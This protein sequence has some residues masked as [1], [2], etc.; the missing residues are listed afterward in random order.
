MKESARKPAKRVIDGNHVEEHF[1]GGQHLPSFDL[2]IYYLFIFRTAPPLSKYKVNNKTVKVLLS[3]RSTQEA[4]P[5]MTF[6]IMWTEFLAFSPF[7]ENTALIL[8]TERE[9]MIMASS[10]VFGTTSVSSLTEYI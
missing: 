1:P 5:T 10:K 8:Y 4:K 2:Y 6:H 7:G 9:P 3:V